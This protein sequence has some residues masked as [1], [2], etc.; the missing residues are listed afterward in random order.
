MPKS[1]SAPPR[2]IWAQL[3]PKQPHRKPIPT[4][5][6]THSALECKSV[7]GKWTVLTGL[8]LGYLRGRNSPP[9]QNTQLPHPKKSYHYSIKV[10]ISEKSSRRDEGSAQ[11]VAFLKIVSQNAPDCISA[12]IHFKKFPGG[13]SPDPPNS[14]PSATR[15]F[16]RKR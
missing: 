4:H 15:G 7:P 5:A 2:A 16:F 9:L 6:G 1:D 13:M 12:Y 10:T 14:W 8:Y 11:T 3:Q